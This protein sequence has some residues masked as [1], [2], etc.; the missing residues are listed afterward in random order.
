MDRWDIA[1]LTTLLGSL[2]AS[3]PTAP[4]LCEGWQA[5]HLVSHLYLRR[6]QPW[7]ALKEEPGSRFAILADQAED[8][9]AY[10][11]L[12]D[13]FESAVPRFSPMALMDGPLGPRMNLLEYVIHDEDVRRGAGPVAPK[14]VPPEE[15]DVIFDSLRGFGR[16]TMRK[17]SV[18]VVFGVPG[19]R[20]QV[21]RRAG[22]DGRSVAVIGAPIELALVAGGRRR[23]ADVDILGTDSAIAAFAASGL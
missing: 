18:G 10:G 9:A 14:A 13:Q 19:G 21:I 23:A 22:A 8:P 4:T 5:R 16:L 7:L 2:R 20:R 6:H 17:A 1:E 15:A 11:V 3:E 12:I